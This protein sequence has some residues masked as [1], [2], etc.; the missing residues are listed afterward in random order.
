MRNGM[1]TGK[2]RIRRETE[3]ARGKAVHY[4]TSIY[5]WKFY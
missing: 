4:K 2:W 5:D 1:K 3:I